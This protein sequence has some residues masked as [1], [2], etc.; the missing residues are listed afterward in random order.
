METLATFTE[1]ELKQ[2]ND[3]A[4]WVEQ[5]G[6]IEWEE[7]VDLRGLNLDELVFIEKRSIEVKFGVLNDV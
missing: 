6:K 7:P 5:V 2:V 1:D 4:I 3:F